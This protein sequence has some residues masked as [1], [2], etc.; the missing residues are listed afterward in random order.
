MVYLLLLLDFVRKY[1]RWARTLTP[2]IEPFL[3]SIPPEQDP[4]PVPSWFPYI[5][6]MQES[7]PLAHDISLQQT[8][9]RDSPGLDPNYYPGNIQTVG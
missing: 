3:L 2:K 8:Q 4:S 7:T 5:T 6:T 1:E 9:Y